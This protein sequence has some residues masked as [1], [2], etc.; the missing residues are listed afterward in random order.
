MRQ[1]WSLSVQEA[2][3]ETLHPKPSL[4]LG[5]WCR[6]TCFPAAPSCHSPWA[7]HCVW[8]LPVHSPPLFPHPKLSSME[9]VPLTT[10]SPELSTQCYRPTSAAYKCSVSLS[11]PSLS[12]HFL[13]FYIQ[14]ISYDICFVWFIS[15]SIISSRSIQV[16]ANVMISFFM[17][18]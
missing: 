1:L 3:T 9:T 13:R 5:V 6:S 10:V 11:K 2:I 12:L 14:V 18:K 4:G 8:F 15:L 16:V 7:Y 17:T